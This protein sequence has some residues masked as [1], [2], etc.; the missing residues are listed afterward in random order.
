MD[1]T[2]NTI[3]V[4]IGSSEQSNISIE[5]ENNFTQYLKGS[6]ALTNIILKCR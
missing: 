6:A 1:L 5:Q 3:L 4:S 2:C